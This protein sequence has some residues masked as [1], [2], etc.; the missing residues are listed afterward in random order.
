MYFYIVSSEWS[1]GQLEA[2]KKIGITQRAPMCRLT[3]YQT[4]DITVKYYVVVHFLNITYDKLQQIERKCLS[5]TRSYNHLIEQYPNNES[6]YNISEEQLFTICSSYFTNDYK[7]YNHDDAIKLSGKTHIHDTKLSPITYQQLHDIMPVVLRGYQLDA[8]KQLTNLFKKQRSV[9]LNILCRCG[10]TEIFKRYIFDYQHKYKYIIYV[11]HR[12]T[13]IAE[14]YKRFDNLLDRRYIALSSGKL[15]I[16]ISDEQLVRVINDD[17]M[18]FVC[19]ESF[20]RLQSILSQLQSTL[21]VFDEAHYLCTNAKNNPVTIIKDMQHVN[22]IYSTATPVFGNYLTSNYI[23]LNDY[24]IFGKWSD[25]VIF[26]DISIAIEQKFISPMKLI[27]QTTGISNRIINAME[28]LQM[29]YLES[30]RKKILLYCNSINS[31]VETY[32]IITTNYKQFTPFKLVSNMSAAEQASVIPSFTSCT[33]PSILVNCQMVTDGINIVDLDTVVYVDL[34]YQKQHVIQSCMRPR[35]Y[36]INKTAYCIIPHVIG[37]DYTTALTIIRELHQLNDPIVVKQISNANKMKLAKLP[38]S[39]ISKQLELIDDVID[40]YIDTNDTIDL[41]VEQIIIRVMRDLLPK[42][43]DEIISACS[44]FTTNDIIT[45]LN[46]MVVNGVI[47]YNESMYYM[48][49]PSKFT[50]E[51]FYKRLRD[52]NC[53]D[54]STY[55]KM[56]KDASWFILDPTSEYKDFSWE[57]LDNNTNFY[58]VEQCRNV[59][60]KLLLTH[61]DTICSTVSPAE[62]LNIMRQYNKK[63]IPYDKLSISLGRL[64]SILS[65]GICLDTE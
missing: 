15:S 14:M 46:R 9:I 20:N 41:T 53:Y 27:V 60:D 39:Q 33:A 44:V 50:L 7:I 23:Y 52:A 49:K 55:I 30:P 57:D 24:R 42:S 63:I 40:Y 17:L 26:N 1:K 62:R 48:I 45:D 59:I 6:R 31:V 58:T 18:I 4:Y 2:V 47:Y 10:K 37:D 16:N 3:E 28:L 64:H 29:I 56:F 54:E 32:N 38:K 8:Y 19:I 43:L 21:I 5:A 22:A 13:L 36:A 61:R 25:A 11:A 51:D 34:R 35:N 65:G 12:L